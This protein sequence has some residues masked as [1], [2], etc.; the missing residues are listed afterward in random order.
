M[1]DP[2]NCGMCGH[3]C[4]AGSLCDNGECVGR[5]PDGSFIPPPRAG[6]AGSMQVVATE[7]GGVQGLVLTPDASTTV[8][9]ADP[10]E[11]PNQIKAR[12]IQVIGGTPRITVTIGAINRMVA[13]E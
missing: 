8:S 12:T 6:V 5:A 1:R 11:D 13:K 4:A 10:P 7:L 2:Q 9:T 3:A